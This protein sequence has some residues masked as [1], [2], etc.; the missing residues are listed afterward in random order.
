MNYFARTIFRE[1][2]SSLLTAFRK[3]FAF[4]PLWRILPRVA[5]RT[6]LTIP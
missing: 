3:T 4:S 5:I 2:G 6:P 1:Q